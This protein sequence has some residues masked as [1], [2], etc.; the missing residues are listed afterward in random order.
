MEMVPK[1]TGY[2]NF[3]WIVER[4]SCGGAAPSAERRERRFTEPE[5]SSV[6]KISRTCPGEN[7]TQKWNI[8]RLLLPQH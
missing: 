7:G 8:K 4:K 3:S 5:R 1:A 6:I 2:P